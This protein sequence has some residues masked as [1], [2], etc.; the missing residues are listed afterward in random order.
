MIVLSK[1]FVAA[2]VCGT[3]RETAKER[4][5]LRAAGRPT[6][7]A[8]AII[9]IVKY[10]GRVRVCYKSLMAFTPT[11]VTPKTG[12]RESFCSANE[13]DFQVRIRTRRRRRIPRRTRLRATLIPAVTVMPVRVRRYP[14]TT[15]FNVD[16]YSCRTF[17]MFIRL[18]LRD[19]LLRVRSG[20]VVV[21]R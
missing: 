8:H 15:T 17:P 20:H 1:R 9:V 7:A 14:A 12:L 19:S 5:S 6:V 16:I 4:K 2:I 11:L 10:A 3:R 13:T 21:T 18:F